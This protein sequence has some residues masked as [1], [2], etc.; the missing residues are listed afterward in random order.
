MRRI[1]SG[2]QRTGHHIGL[3]VDHDDMLAVP[4]RLQ[5]LRARAASDQRI[6][7]VTAAPPRKV[8]KSRRLI[9]RPI[10]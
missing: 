6:D 7:G 3:D 9:S 4:D 1:R 10:I 8:T 2:E 5:V